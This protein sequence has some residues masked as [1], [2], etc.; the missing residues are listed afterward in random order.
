MSVFEIVC[1]TLLGGTVLYAMA[2][3]IRRSADPEQR[4]RR[5]A[6]D[7]YGTADAGGAP[8]AGHIRRNESSDGVWWPFGGGH[9][10]DGGGGDSSGGGC[11]D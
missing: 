3:G 5:Q 6:G 8:G 4:R 9:S 1:L 11:G 2:D 10:T 7:V